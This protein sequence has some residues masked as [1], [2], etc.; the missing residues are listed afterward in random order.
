[1]KKFEYAEEGTRR[2]NTCVSC[3]RLSHVLHPFYIHYISY[4][5]PVKKASTFWNK[6]LKVEACLNF[7]WE[8]SLTKA[9]L[10]LVQSL[11]SFSNEK[12][13][14]RNSGGT[15]RQ[16]ETKSRKREK[17]E[18]YRQRETKRKKE[19]R[20]R[21]KERK[22]ERRRENKRKKREKLREIE[23]KLREKRR[24]RERKDVQGQ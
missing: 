9:K 3:P 1:M 7:F 13:Y 20:K 4:I 15:L 22:R 14:R 6:F 11:S 16:K 2:M 19:R 23:R 12:N 17:S 5:H 18:K 10:P 24:K 8:M 21:E